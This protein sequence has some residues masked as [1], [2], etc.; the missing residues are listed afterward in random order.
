MTIIEIEFL[1]SKI[2]ISPYTGLLA[3]LLLW[4]PFLEG[5]ASY[6][7]WTGSRL[8]MLGAVFLAL[9]RSANR[10]G[11]PARRSMLTVWW[12][13]LAGV[14]LTEAAFAKYSFIATQWT[15]SYAAMA[16]VFFTAV[17]VARTGGSSWLEITMLLAGTFEA[18]L[19]IAQYIGVGQ[20]R[21]SGTMFNASYFGGY[22]S[23]LSAIPFSRIVFADRKELFKSKIIIYG[24]IFLL[25][26]AGILVSGSRGAIV[27][28]AVVLLAVGW[29]RFGIKSVILA[30]AMAALLVAIPN[31]VQKRI[32]RL[33]DT[34]VYAWSRVGIWR[35]SIMMIA[36]RPWGVGP[37]MFRF[38]S[39]PYAF[40]I[41]KAYANF[42]KF[43]EKA[44]DSYLDLAV[45]L[46]PLTSAIVIGMIVYILFKG[47][48]AAR[49]GRSPDIASRVGMLAAVSA[50]ALVDSIHKCPAVAFLGIISGGIIWASIGENKS[51]FYIPISNGLRWPVAVIA[52]LFT[53]MIV[54][55]TAGYYLKE[56]AIESSLDDA[57]VWLNRALICSPNNAEF[58]LLRGNMEK[59]VYQRNG[60][61]EYLQDAIKDFS[62]AAEL[63]PQDGNYPAAIAGAL[64]EVAQLSKDKNQKALSYEEAI[65]YYNRTV[66]LAPKNPFLYER[67]AELQIEIGK[68][69]EAI[70]SLRQAIDIEPNYLDARR[71][72]AISLKENGKVAEAAEQYRLLT[73]KI[74]IIPKGKLSEYE[75]ALAEVDRE[76]VSKEKTEI[77]SLLNGGGFSEAKPK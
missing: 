58:W 52:I 27:S 24:F 31:P 48:A 35:S 43:P 10:G 64:A 19:G 77:E 61:P 67:K 6:L 45:E 2:N 13:V 36:D 57:G 9:W 51:T 60:D 65:A 26:T 37:G 74:K 72:L 54:A 33:S 41:E 71:R 5:G 25:F 8:L 42:G 73:D 28:M 1:K 70:K 7:G 56:K 29:T 4:S 47:S 20:A 38:Y 22:L 14:L 62:Y 50:H 12:I 44:H 68:K 3:A 15:M 46:S 16:V 59:R 34:D 32:M 53:W 69:D 11:I 63:N 76:A 66:E 17:H 30:I 21:A 39:Q 55:P 18:C 40:R 49:R 23:A 75:R